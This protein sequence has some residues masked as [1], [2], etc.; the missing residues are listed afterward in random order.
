MSVLKMIFFA[1][2][3]AIRRAFQIWSLKTS[4]N[5]GLKQE[6]KQVN[7][8]WHSILFDCVS[9]IELQ[10]FFRA[11]VCGLDWEDFWA[12]LP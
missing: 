7:S 3:F 4:F 10:Y 12:Y 1:W 8:F 9:F 11:A 5:S 2:P 6:K